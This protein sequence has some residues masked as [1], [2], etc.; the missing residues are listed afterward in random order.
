MEDSFTR[1][2][3]VSESQQKEFPYRIYEQVYFL[4][5]MRHNR[6][7][8]ADPISLTI[9]AAILLDLLNSNAIKIEHDLVHC[10]GTIQDDNILEEALSLIRNNTLTLKELL[11]ALNGESFLRNRNMHLKKVRERIGKE[12]ED[13][14]VLSY[15]H[16]G[17][18][19]KG[20]PRLNFNAKKEM[21]DDVFLFLEGEH[22]IRRMS[23]VGCL[24]YCDALKPLFVSQPLPKVVQME[25]RANNIRRKFMTRYVGDDRRENGI[26]AVIRHLH[27]A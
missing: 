20:Q 7:R 6:P 18:F 21:M 14:G 9:R 8:I 16:K 17:K 27:K 3:F 12:L 23:V 13:R 1:K 26:Y 10:C 15:D 19:F 22:N 2:R 5:K 4:C 11:V 25:E 24:M